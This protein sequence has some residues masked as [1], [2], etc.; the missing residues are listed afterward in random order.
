LEQAR[1]VISKDEDLS[2]T[3]EYLDAKQMEA[4]FSGLEIPNVLMEFFGMSPPHHCFLG[5]YSRRIL[6]ELEELDQTSEAPLLVREFLMTHDLKWSEKVWKQVSTTIRGRIYDLLYRNGLPMVNVR[7]IRGRSMSL[8]LSEALR[9]TP[10]V[11]QNDEWVNRQRNISDPAVSIRAGPSQMQVMANV[12]EALIASRGSSRTV[13]ASRR[14]SGGGAD[15][16]SGG[17]DSSSSDQDPDVRRNYGAED[18]GPPDRRARVCDAFS[19]LTDSY[20]RQDEEDA[21]VDFKISGVGKLVKSRD[22]YH[23]LPDQSVRSMVHTLLLY[24]REVGVPGDKVSRVSLQALH[25]LLAGQ[26]FEVYKREIV[27]DVRVKTIENAARILERRFLPSPTRAEN[28]QLFWQRGVREMHGDTL[29]EQLEEFINYGS[30][31]SHNLVSPVS[32]L[33]LKTRLLSG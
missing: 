33:V 10:L 17:G 28:T 13:R 31:M 27:P 14:L 9:V 8:V 4:E 1:V 7:V 30:R 18:R 11:F 15:D 26:A 19:E 6:H 32:D 21:E 3:L 29:G 16:P 2:N 23:G 22:V 20:K 25:H 24:A 5:A 12:E